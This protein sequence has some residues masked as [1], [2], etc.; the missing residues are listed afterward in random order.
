[1]RALLLAC[2][3]LVLG[4]APGCLLFAPPDPVN[5]RTYTLE[6]VGLDEG[7]EVVREALR[8][9]AVPRFG[10]GI[11]ISW[12]AELLNMALDPVYAGNRRMKLY[13]HFVPREDDL[14]LEILAL[15]EHLEESEGGQ[16]GWVRPMMDVPLEEDFFQACV[17]ELLARRGPPL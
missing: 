16:P 9:Y 15:V 8:D 14:D 5:F 11:G 1:M 4:G 3:L 6:G 17:N 13:I 12:D 7:V 10:G 2:A